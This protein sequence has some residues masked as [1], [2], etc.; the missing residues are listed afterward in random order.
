MESLRAFTSVG[1]SFI[2]TFSIQ[3]TGV[4]AA[5]VQ[6]AT[7]GVGITSGARRTLTEIASILVDALGSC[8]T[9]VAQTF[10]QIR[11]LTNCDVYLVFI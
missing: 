6:R 10:I 3:T 11:A 1:A 8:S 5:L 4:V 2:V 7:V 9:R